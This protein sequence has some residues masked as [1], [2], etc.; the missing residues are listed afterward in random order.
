MILKGSRRV[1]VCVEVGLSVVCL[2]GCREDGGTGWE[3][4]VARETREKEAG[5]G[6]NVFGEIR[7]EHR[8]GTA[9]HDRTAGDGVGASGPGRGVPLNRKRL[10]RTC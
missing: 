9:A 3:R 4:E 1:L 10:K 5:R 6:K 2:Q 7:M 8:G